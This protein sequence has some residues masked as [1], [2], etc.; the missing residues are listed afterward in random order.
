[1][2]TSQDQVGRLLSLIPYLQGHPGIR[3]DEAAAAFGVSPAQIVRDLRI[4]WMCGLPGG[5]PDDLIEI[6]MDAVEGAGRIVLSNADFLSR[7]MRFTRDEVMSLVVAL[8]VVAEMAAGDSADAVRSA[9]TKLE[10]LADTAD[11][12]RVAIRVEGGAGPVR[13][14]LASA[15]SQGVRVRLTYDGLVRGRTTTPVVDPV[16]IDLRDGAA[17]LQAFSLDRQ[18]WR[19]YRLDRIVTVERIGEPAG[20]HGA[21]PAPVREWFDDQRGDNTVTVALRPSARWITEYY[22]MIDTPGDVV[23][24]DGW[25]PATFPVADPRWLTSLLLRLGD[26]VRVVA[27]RGAGRNA[28]ERAREALALLGPGEPDDADPGHA[29]PSGAG[30]AG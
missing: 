16:R 28:V 13:E 2:S 10:A 1:M 22:P 19:T 29:D 30:P 18:A 8:R 5:L 9:L 26:A 24:P 27:P 23:V 25:E 3:V 6:D 20:D 4:A 17:Y 14:L 12:R 21:P 7:P 15:I 11:T